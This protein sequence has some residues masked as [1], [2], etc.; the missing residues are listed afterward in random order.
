MAG[1]GIHKKDEITH[2]ELLKNFKEQLDDETGAVASF[3]GIVRKDSKKEGNVK[4]LQYEAAEDV[5]KDLKEI[6]KNVEQKIE[7]ISEVYI[8]HLIDDLKPGDE[9]IYVLIGGG[10]REEVF[11]ALP[12]V[13]NQVKSKAR[14][15]KKEITDGEDYWVHEVEKS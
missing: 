4:E 8:H 2:S 5:E 6:A 1:S 3:I 9:I 13:M 15:W 10:H 12:K 11:E 7:G 14:I